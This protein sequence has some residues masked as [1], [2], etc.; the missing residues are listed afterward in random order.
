MLDRIRDGDIKNNFLCNNC[1]WEDK[2]GNNSKH[3]ITPDYRII[4]ENDEVER[5]VTYYNIY[6]CNKCGYK[7]HNDDTDCSK[8]KNTMC[9]LCKQVSEQIESQSEEEEVEETEEEVEDEDEGLEHLIKEDESILYLFK[10]LEDAEDEVEE[11]EEEEEEEVE[12]EE[13]EE[14]EEEEEE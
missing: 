9:M 10:R 5:D 13:T 14:E 1:Y 3:I 4:E 12:V 6:I 11:T 8:C 7:T 2:E